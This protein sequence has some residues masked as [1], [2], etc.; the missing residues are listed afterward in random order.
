MQDSVIFTQKKRKEKK[1]Q[2]AGEKYTA[3]CKHLYSKV[4]FKITTGDDPDLNY[5]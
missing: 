4:L 2:S 1:S 3:F 5:S